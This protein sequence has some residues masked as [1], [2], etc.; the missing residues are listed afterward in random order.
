MAFENEQLLAGFDIPDRY[1]A[2]FVLLE[3]LRATRWVAAAGGETFT[4][5]ATGHGK[6][7]V[8]VPSEHPHLFSG[9]YFA[10]AYGVI[11]ITCREVLTVRTDEDDAGHINARIDF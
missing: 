7:E 10:N 8:R 1:F 11:P 2:R 5:R 6:H 4:I 9:L 3:E